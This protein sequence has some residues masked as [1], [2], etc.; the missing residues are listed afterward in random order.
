MKHSLK[1]KIVSLALVGILALSAACPVSA[2]YTS[3][4]ISSGAK[5]SKSGNKALGGPWDWGM[6]K[7]YQ[8]YSKYN[9]SSQKHRAGV[10]TPKTGWVFT[11]ICSRNTLTYIERLQSNANKGVSCGTYG[12]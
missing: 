10:Y 8:T 11:A 3:Q 12:A 1:K 6:W 7:S 4:S 5:C 9:H 2:A